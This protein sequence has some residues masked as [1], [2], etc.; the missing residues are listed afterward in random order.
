MTLRITSYGAARTVTGSA[1]LIELDRARILIDFG[2]FQ[3]PDTSELNDMPLEFDPRS[4]DAV[5]V[6]HGHF[7]HI[8]RLPL[9]FQQGYKGPIY[10]TRATK[11]VM[12][13][14][15]LNS[16]RIQ[17]DDY[18]Y[19]RGRTKKDGRVPPPMYNEQDV[20]R[21]L[22]AVEVVRQNEPFF[23]RGV[24]VRFGHSGHILGASFIELLGRNHRFVT[25]GDLGHWGP[26]VVPDPAMPPSSVDV[27]MIETTYGDLIHRPLSE[28]VDE[29]VDLI[30]K[31]NRNKGNLLIPSFS[32][33]RT[34]DVLHQLRLAYDKR[35]IPAKTKVYLDSPLGIRFT[36]L[37][38]RYP[39]LLTHSVKQCI[40]RRENP[41]GW[42]NVQFTRSARESRDIQ[43]RSSGTVIMAGSG[44]A[45]GG[46]ILNHLKR[47]IERPECAV[48]FVGFQAEGTLGR[49]LV[50]GAKVAEI[51]GEPYLVRA[52]ITKIDGFS[53]HADQNEIVRWVR[54]AGKP[55][56]L[57]VH[58][59]EEAPV[60]VQ[61]VLR[62]KHNITSTIV[63]RSQTYEF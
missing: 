50:E 20:Y 15:L 46:R 14:I 16:A 48:A 22:D 57:L 12:R 39:E 37:Y 4:L 34:Q 31:T 8:G 38:R 61:N 7:D 30:H 6:T 59:E 40:M 21:T 35:R 56:V 54:A 1:H 27:L 32:L 2:M 13:L 41:F 60:A 25:S 44:M 47:H 10:T 51:E 49:E 63:E 36:E 58:G 23:I 42:D 24:R 28:A 43:R 53:V 33:A 11:D 52:H 9:L 19:Q 26:H 18:R 55:H 62:D 3:G 45:T 17:Q 29:L 5:L